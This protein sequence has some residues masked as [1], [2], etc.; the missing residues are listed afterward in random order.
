MTKFE[1]VSVTSG[2]TLLTRTGPG[3][4]G[5]V[6]T[7]SMVVAAPFDVLSEGLT[8]YAK[9]WLVQ[10]ALP[11]LSATAREFILTGTLPDEW[12]AIFGRADD[13]LAEGDVI[14]Y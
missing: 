12:D 6:N 9:G 1:L 2:T 8:R 14:D 3:L 10:D 5:P 7:K 4:F 13:G 11:S